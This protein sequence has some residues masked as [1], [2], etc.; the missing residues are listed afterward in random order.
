[1]P[2]GLLFLYSLD[3]LYSIYINIYIIYIY[4]LVITK[5]IRIKY[6]PLFRLFLLFSVPWSQ[7]RNIVRAWRLAAHPVT[8][9]F[10]HLVP[11]V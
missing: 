8:T 3:Y 7:S 4:I 6:S 11:V 2:A 5:E 9:K 10:N 1:M